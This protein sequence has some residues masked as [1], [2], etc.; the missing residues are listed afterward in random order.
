MV[1]NNTDIHVSIIATPEVDGSALAGIHGVLTSF[2]EFVPN[3]VRFTVEVILP[4]S[5]RDKILSGSHIINNVLGIPIPIHRLT[6]EVEHTNI[7]IIPSLYLQQ[8][9]WPQNPYPDLTHWLMA[10]YQNGAQLCSACTGAM[11]LAETG[12]LDGYRATQHWAFE[13]L[14]RAR[15]PKVE[16]C[17]DKVLLATGLHERILMT[18]ASAAWHDLVVYLIT[19]YASA[20]AAQVMAKFFLLNLHHEGQTPYIIFHDP[21]QHGDAKIAIAQARMRQSFREPNT[22]DQA[23]R[24]SGLPPRTFNRRFRKA[25]GHTPI[26]HV[27]HL[28]IEQAKQDLATSNVPVDEIS[29]RVGYEDPT[30]FRRLFKRLTGMT[31]RDYRRKFKID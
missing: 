26:A 25:I 2:T 21:V 4:D 9:P 16:L 24:E 23:M 6:S 19:R 5:Q 15:F 28:R 11:L 13:Q 3:S 20:E 7:V 12:L 29:W 10:M 18:G 22:I 31:A 8:E 1:V 17:I 30:F 27:Q 14:F